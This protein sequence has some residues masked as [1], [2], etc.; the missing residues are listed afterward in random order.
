M[1]VPI[2]GGTL[3]GKLKGNIRQGPKLCISAK[4]EHC[5]APNNWGSHAV[6][7][8]NGAGDFFALALVVKTNRRGAE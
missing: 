5:L 4:S 8:T 1:F 6:D 2:Q 7:L 3:N